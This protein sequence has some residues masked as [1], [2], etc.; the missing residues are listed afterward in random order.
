MTFGILDAQ[1]LRTAAP[2]ILINEKHVSHDCLII[3]QNIRLTVHS[4][5]ESLCTRGKGWSGLLPGLYYTVIHT[6]YYLP[7]FF[8][9]LH[10]MLYHK[11]YHIINLITS[12]HIVL[13]HPEYNV[14]L[15]HNCHF[16]LTCIIAV[17]T[18]YIFILIL[19]YFIFYLFLFLYSTT[20]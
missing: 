20:C 8:F 15:S 13:S 9:R 18:L 2:G 10:F 19:F 7:Q 16:I 14:T 12:Y 17:Y 5:S 4:F 11:S 1:V 6:V 3:L